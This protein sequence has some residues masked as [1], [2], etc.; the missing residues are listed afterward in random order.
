MTDGQPPEIM[1]LQSLV[2]F[3]LP[4]VDTILGEAHMKQ[5]LLAA[6]VILGFAVAPV[7]NATVILTFGQTGSNTTTAT[8]NGAGTSTTI[9]NVNT[10]ITITQIDSTNPVVV[11]LNAFYNF[12]ATSVGAASTT[13]VP[14]QVFT[15]S[16]EITS[17][18][19]D[20][21]T[22]YLSGTFTDI[23]LANDTSAILSASAPP[24]AVSFTSSVIS[25]LGLPRAI[26]LSFSNVTPGVLGLDN[27]T[28]PSFT[29]AVSGTFSANTPAP[30]PT[31]LV[32]L[33]SGLLGLG[34]IARR[35]R[36]V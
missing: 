5:A 20:T 11:P 16:F 19:N 8:A 4:D 21:G 17:G 13:P 27:T 29:A 36:Q 26:S 33:G 3:L 10:P 7:A 34:V 18:A 23:T 28:L 14:N 30:E 24:N 12:T 25:V 6:T 15:G 2:R 35:R 22:N 31:S 9:S 32:L 1:G